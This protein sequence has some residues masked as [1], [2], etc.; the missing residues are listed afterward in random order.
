MHTRRLHEEV[1]AKE[2]KNYIDDLITNEWE[3]KFKFGIDEPN[4][5]RPLERRKFALCIDY[6]KLNNKII[7][8]RQ[9]IR[10]VQDMLDRLGGKAVVLYPRYEYSIP[11]RIYSPRFKNVYSAS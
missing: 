9:P 3:K 5:M 8:G 1:L 10:K 2:C 4:S 11:P 6:R 7:P